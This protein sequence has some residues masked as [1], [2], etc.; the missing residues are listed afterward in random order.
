MKLD[1]KGLYR[2]KDED[3]DK[4][5]DMF[6]GAFKNYE[7]LVG[8]YPDW[9]DRQAAIEM[10]IAY[11]LAY[12][13][14]YGAAYSL[15]EKI[16]EA[17]VVCHSDD[18]DYTDERIAEANCE[19]DRFK[20]AAAKLSDEQVQF[21]YDFFDEFDRQEAALKIP[22]PHIYVDYVAVREG[23]QG[24]GRGSKIIAR[25]KDYADEQGLPVMLFT[26]GADDI[27]FYM[28]NGFKVIGVTRS[29]EFKFENTY[30]LYEPKA[31][32]D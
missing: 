12:D 15:D 27:A 17:I 2:I 16:D 21:W 7:K 19:N 28:K 23:L 13:W 10:V 4:L 14:K 32:A 11:Y 29:A 18:I 9:D 24:K 8:A 3:Y 6:Q 25:L 31:K 22:A 5:Y 30:M 26:N 20:A 1:I